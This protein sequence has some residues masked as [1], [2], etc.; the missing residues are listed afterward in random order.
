MDTAEFTR[1]AGY[2]DF[3]INRYFHNV[4]P[5]RLVQ[6]CTETRD[7]VLDR[8]NLGAAQSFIQILMGLSFAAAFKLYRPNPDDALMSKPLRFIYTYIYILLESPL[9][10]LPNDTKFNIFLFIFFNI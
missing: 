10:F 3:F 5:S 1:N 9:N 4:I 6:E 7:F 2:S 8:F